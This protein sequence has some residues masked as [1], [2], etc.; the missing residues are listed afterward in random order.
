MCYFT[1]LWCLDNDADMG[2]NNEADTMKG[3]NIRTI[4][5]V[6]GIICV[7]MLSRKERRE[8]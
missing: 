8:K 7:S 1:D 4:K 5:S 2:T 6:R 3:H